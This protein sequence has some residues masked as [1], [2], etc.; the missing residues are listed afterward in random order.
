MRGAKVVQSAMFSCVTLERRVPAG[1]PLREI[2]VLVDRALERMDG[3]LGAMYARI[4]RPSVSPE[5][6]LRT[7]LLQIL[8][9]VPSERRMMEQLDYNLLFRWFVGLEM[10][11][12]VW[13][14]TVFTKNRERLIGAEVSQCLLEAVLVEG[15]GAPATQRGAF[16]CRRDVD[17]GVGGSPQFPGQIRSA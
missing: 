10:D 16:H 17:P 5:K 7:S 4:G 14:V 8:Y 12:A 6:L 11:D 13:D 1:H 15:A 3:E 2:R 9:S